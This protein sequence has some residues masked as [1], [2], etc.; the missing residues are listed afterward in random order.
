MCDSPEHVS[1]AVVGDGYGGRALFP[2]LPIHLNGHTLMYLNLHR[3]VGREG[4]GA[5]GGGEG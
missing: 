1:P 4:E 2:R 3:D 5:G